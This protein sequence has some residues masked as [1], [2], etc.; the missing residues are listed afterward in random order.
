MDPTPLF[1]YLLGLIPILLAR[2][3]Q[4]RVVACAF[5]VLSIGLGVY[6]VWCVQN[7][8]TE[9]EG[10]KMIAFPLIGAFCITAISVVATYFVDKKFNAKP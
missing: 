4:A 7:S 2:S 5:G 3:W 10:V 6:Y 1:P 9:L 8:P